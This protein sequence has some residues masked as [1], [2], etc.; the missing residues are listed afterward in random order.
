[1]DKWFIELFVGKDSIEDIKK[2]FYKWLKKIIDDNGL[3][4]FGRYNVW[5]YYYG[6]FKRLMWLFFIYEVLIIIIKVMKRKVSGFR[7]LLL[8]I[9]IGFVY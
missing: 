5:I 9:S 6:I 2:R 8:I 7:V 1:M 3:L 4:V